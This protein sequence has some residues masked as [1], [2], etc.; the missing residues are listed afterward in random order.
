MIKKN[1][2]WNFRRLP[3]SRVSHT[4]IRRS[5]VALY[6]FL[7]MV[8]LQLI[9]NPAW[10]EIKEGNI[11]VADTFGGTRELG[12]LILI[13]PTTGQRTELSDFGN[14]MQ[15]MLGYGPSG[16]AVDTDGWIYVSDMFG[17]DPETYTGGAIYEVD[18]DTGNRSLISNFAQ[19]KIQGFLFSGLDVDKKSQ[20]LA[21]KFDSIVRI[22]PD[23]DTRTIVTDLKNPAQGATETN[24]D[25]FITDLVLERTGKIIIG[26][27]RSLLQESGEYDSAIFRVHPVTGKRTLLSDFSNPSQ[28]ADLVDLWFN[29]GLVV[30]AS[31]HI[32][33]AAGNFG[34]DLLLSID[35]KSGQ[36]TVL[37]DFNN[38]DQGAVGCWVHGLSMEKSG[39]ILAVASKQP[40]CDRTAVY[41]VNPRTGQRTLLSDPD[42]PN[43][44]P[45]IHAGGYVAVVPKIRDKGR[46]R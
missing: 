41:R 46:H 26:T 20:L 34:S 14:S 45:L 28:G 5:G 1:Y 27:A 10:A 33:A 43:Q 44:G 36:R 2:R 7:F 42:N 3:V 8:G 9:G 21:N 6:C 24:P 29:A 40:E 4:G 31:G 12:A 17:G 35:P 11:L 22:N 38:P 19:G 37:S 15:G 16:V 13:D 30:D 18:S 23:T 39:T 25:R 32:L